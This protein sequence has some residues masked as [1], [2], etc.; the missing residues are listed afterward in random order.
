MKSVYDGARNFNYS[1]LGSGI[2]VVQMIVNTFLYWFYESAWNKIK[3]G[4][5]K[6]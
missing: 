5:N 4:K 6:K 2:A 3:W 1:L